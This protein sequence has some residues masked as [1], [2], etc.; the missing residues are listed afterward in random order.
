M[1][2][3]CADP[4]EP[5]RVD[6]CFAAE[7]EAARR[8]GW[9]VCVVNLEELEA[10]HL[11]RALACVPQRDTRRAL[12][13]GWMMRPEVYVRLHQGLSAR[14]V[15][16]LNSPEHYRHAHHL[17]EN[18]AVISLL[19]APTTWLRLPPGFTWEWI[20][21][22]LPDLLRP[23]GDAPVLVKDYVKSQKH[24]WKEACFIPCAS[25]AMAVR[26]VVQRFLEL[27]DDALNEG[28][29]FRQYIPLASAGTHPVS[30]MPL[31]VE[32]RLFFLRGQVLSSS[33]YWEHG[34]DGGVRPDLAM[35][36][37]VARKV[38]SPFF[39]MDVA[40]RAD[41]QWMI[42]ELGDGGVSSLP[43]RADVD[44]FYRRLAAR[45]AGR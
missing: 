4:L 13:R 11:K 5:S 43:E 26:L 23:F 7:A 24:A 36:T 29:V 1:L 45:L 22:R 18:H 3:L 41:G 31:G 42:V 27:Q 16:L 38:A 10:G 35:F 6:P 21:A 17:P 34:A 20:E 12:Y 33:V 25:D 32:F 44:D 15:R 37:D 8:A 39:A 9:D 28:L 19:T 30:G 40:L 14:N 2:V